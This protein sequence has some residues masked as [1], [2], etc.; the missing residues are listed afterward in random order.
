MNLSIILMAIG[1]IC[2]ILSFFF[3]DSSKKVEKELE[4]LS[5]SI[6][7]ETNSLKRRVKLI[8]EELLLDSNLNVPL[9]NGAKNKKVSYSKDS[10]NDLKGINEILIQQ[11][12]ELNK[13]GYSL[14]DIKKLS[15][16]N[17]AQILLI[18]QQNGGN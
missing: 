5:I 8:E 15:S 6:Y 10:K 2:I 9:S 4:D 17:E 14:A 7:Q 13:Q 11:V 3:K 12:I 16:L 1:I 18:L